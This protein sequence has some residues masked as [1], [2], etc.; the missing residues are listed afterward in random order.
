MLGIP[1][2]IELS[3]V[4]LIVVCDQ[5]TF[6]NRHVLTLTEL[7]AK[8]QFGKR[9]GSRSFPME[10]GLADEPPEETL[11]RLLDQELPGMAPYIT[12]DYDRPIGCYQVVPDVWVLVLQATTAS[13]IQII[14]DCDDD[15]TDH[16]WELLSEVLA[17]NNLRAGAR[18]ALDDCAHQRRGQVR[19]TCALPN[20]LACTLS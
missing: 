17:N 7:H 8:P 2:H 20:E 16:R 15:V 5:P 10:T 4:G 3:G 12:I 13:P 9:A 11:R 19:Y 18:E 6:K 14:G 1:S